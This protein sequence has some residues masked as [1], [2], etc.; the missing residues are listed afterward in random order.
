MNAVCIEEQPLE[1]KTWQGQ[2]VVTFKDVDRVHR[3]PEGTAS[4]NF[5]K[6]RKH[7]LETVD[8]YEISSDEIRRNKI[9][10]VP[11]ALKRSMIFLTETGYLML[12]KSFTDDLAW[13]V[14]RA[15][16][17]NYFRAREPEQQQ[18]A[19]KPK[20]LMLNGS[21][22]MTAT[23]VMH[24][25]G[26]SRVELRELLRRYHV[27]RFIIEGDQ[28]RR[29]KD[30]NHLHSSASRM[31][32]FGWMNVEALLR[33]IGKLDEFND[34]LMEYF[35]PEHRKDLSDDDMRI[36]VEQAR[37][38]LEAGA[39]MK[40]AHKSAVACQAATALLINIGL[41]NERHPGFDG[42]TANFWDVTPEGYNKNLIM[43]YARKR[44]PYDQK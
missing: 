12:V 19:L 31:M 11:E 18:M 44:W 35:E 13:K 1:I 33:C 26:C 38:L 42:I 32:I 25:L 40:E 23:D 4:R 30:E 24:L 17:N 28:L 29:F 9:M 39:R 8:F 2:R 3:R 15:L 27:A 21:P 14:Q 36:A 16:V 7:F 34:Y 22:V 37:L 43:H 41:W 6:N 5:R 10:S 20:R